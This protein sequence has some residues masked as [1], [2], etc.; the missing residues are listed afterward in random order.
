[1]SRTILAKY[2][3]PWKYRR[4]LREQAERLAAL[5]RRDG[6]DCRR[7]RKPLRFDL[8]QGHDAGVRVEAIVPTSAGG[9]EA[10]D[11]LCLTHRRCNAETGDMT[12]EVRERL[13]LQREASLFSTERK[14]RRRA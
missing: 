11:N 8:P 1:M 13:R 4:E 3:T 6:D 7:C 5:R 9:S 12:A 2:V 10:L 14:K